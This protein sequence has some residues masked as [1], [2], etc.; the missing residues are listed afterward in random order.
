MWKKMYQT[1]GVQVPIR[2]KL[3]HVEITAHLTPPTIR[4][5]KPNYGKAR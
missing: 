5:K 1:Y 4:T 2:I 3:N